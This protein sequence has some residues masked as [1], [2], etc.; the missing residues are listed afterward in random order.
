MAGRGWTFSKIDLSYRSN[1]EKEVRILREGGA[2]GERGRKRRK[3]GRKGNLEDALES[4]DLE[5][6]EFLSP[7]KSPPNTNRTGFVWNRGE[8]YS[9]AMRCSKKLNTLL[10]GRIT[11]C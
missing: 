5:W 11:S 2:K 8:P 1:P 4:L 10:V 9:P 6:K 3:V 7:L